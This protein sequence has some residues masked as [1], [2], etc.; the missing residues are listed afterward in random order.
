MIHLIRW[1]AII[2]GTAFLLWAWRPKAPVYRK[3]HRYNFN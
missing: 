1:A 2:G 3:R